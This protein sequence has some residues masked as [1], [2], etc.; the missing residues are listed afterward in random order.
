MITGI[1]VCKTCGSQARNLSVLSQ[2]KNCFK[3]KTKSMSHIAFNMK[4]LITEDWSKKNLSSSL[5]VFRQLWPASLSLSL[6]RF[7]R[8]IM[9]PGYWGILGTLALAEFSGCQQDIHPSILPFTNKTPILLDVAIYS[10]FF[11]KYFAKPL[12]QVGQLFDPVLAR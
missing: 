8:G 12:L 2:K 1:Q 6:S 7:Q 10:T 3:Y 4:G 5:S 11:K 9:V